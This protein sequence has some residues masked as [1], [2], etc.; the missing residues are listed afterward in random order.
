MTTDNKTETLVGII[1]KLVYKLLIYRTTGFFY[2]TSETALD[3][4]LNLLNTI[5]LE[6]GKL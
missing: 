6:K 5:S 2:D 3:A 1:K 4:E